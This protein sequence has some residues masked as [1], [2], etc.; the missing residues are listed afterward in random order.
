MTAFA[1]PIR[2][3]KNSHAGI[4]FQLDRLSELPA[5]L[6]P[7][8]LA[9]RTAES[10]VKFF[11]KAVYA[12]H[13]D[14]EK[15]L[16]PSVLESAAAGEERKTVSSAIK[17]LVAQHRNL[18]ALWETLEPELKKVAKGTSQQVQTRALETLV[19]LYKEHAEYEETVFLPMAQ[20]I[21]SRNHNHM[22]AMG[23]SLHLHHMPAPIGHI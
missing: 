10:A 19:K 2:T 14:E 13:A 12:H 16:F 3:F 21:L 9:K 17:V 6:A 1:R 22:E 23:L 15:V 18:E 5:L 7:A 4:V 11:R 8:E 20:D